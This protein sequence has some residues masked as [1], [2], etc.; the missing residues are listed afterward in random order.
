MK[1]SILFTILLLLLTGNSVYGQEGEIMQDKK[2]TVL[3]KVID[4]VKQEQKQI[5]GTDIQGIHQSIQIE[6][7][8]GSAKGRIVVVNDDFL[9]L[10]KGQKFYLLHTVRWEGGADLYSVQEPYRLPKVFI[11]VG[12][13]LLSVFVF[14]G[15]Q[16]IRG[17]VSLVGS[18][19]LILYVLLPGILQGYSPILITI[20]VSS[21]IIILGSYVTHGFNK[22]TSSAVVGMIATVIFTGILGYVAVISTGLS[23]YGSE[24][25]VYLNLNARGSI[26]VV[27]LLFGG[28]MIGLLGVL[29]D[30]AIGQAITVEE[31]LRIAPHVPRK[32]IYQRAIRIGREHIGALV[33]TLAIAYVGAALP[34]LLLVL[35]ASTDSIWVVLNRESFSTEIIRTTI[36]SLGLILAVPIT[37]IITMWMLNRGKKV[38]VDKKLIEKEEHA[39]EHVGHKH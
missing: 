16:G 14:G 28:I 25:I 37:T 8:E 17:L 24:E 5:P 29:Y 2:E 6:I 7:L 26:D 1:K 23:G 9:E 32:T 18:F 38:I 27:G 3:S 30:V 31:L 10:K 20:S 11:F 13:F 34:M 4:I 33:N 12:I 21:L 15:I 19:I 39:L 36:G 35:Q 22:T